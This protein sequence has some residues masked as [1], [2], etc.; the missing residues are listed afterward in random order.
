MDIYKKNREIL[1]RRFPRFE[2]LL[3]AADTSMYCVESSR[4]GQ[5]VPL[6]TGAGGKKIAV[7]SKYEPVKEAER[8]LSGVLDASY[9]LYIVAGFGFAYHLEILLDAMKKDSV[10]LVLDHDIAA[11][12]LALQHRDLSALLADERF[13][14]LLDPDDDEIAEIL[15]GRSSKNVSIIA[16]RGSHQCAADY[17][18]NLIRKAKAY[19]STKE[20]NIATLAKFEKLWTLNCVKNMR[21]FALMPGA[22]VFYG[23]FSDCDAIVVCAGPSL[24]NDLEWLKS[25]SDKAV[26][27]G[28]DTSYTVLANAGIQPH[29]CLCVDPQLINARYFEGMRETTTVIVA[30]PT[31]HSAVFRFYRGRGVISSMPFDMMKWTEQITGE[32]GEMTHGGSVSTNACDFAKRLGVRRIFLLGQDLS[33]TKDRAHVKGSY[34]DELLHNSTNRFVT[35][36]VQNRRQVRALPPLRMPS[37]S[38]AEV[39]TNQKMMIFYQWF[40]RHSSPALFNA[41]GDGLLFKNIPHVVRDGIV[42]A[43]PQDGAIARRIDELFSAYNASDGVIEEIRDRA[44]RLYNESSIL[45][46]KLDRALVLT[47]ELGGERSEKKRAQIIEKL[48]S[49]D[50]YIESASSAKGMVG[51]A[52]QRVIHTI[53]EGYDEGGSSVLARSEYLYS[54][55]RD[56]ALFVSRSLKKLMILLD[57]SSQ[58]D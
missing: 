41:S 1:A 38:G 29:F 26:I 37:I 19:L 34:L 11:F 52:V 31:V 20:V 57:S 8:F 43:E 21:H 42:F 45:A 56:G 16:H 15:K 22:N 23:R 53:T 25:V 46:E 12:K 13:L 14:Y 50:R 35:R 2:T 10:L 28:V 32:K 47:D 55:L 33:F 51:L 58:Q 24:E 7:H 44:E 6:Y 4:T 5:P 17:Y 27:V 54:G 36:L 9:N 18:Q 48:E 3:D 30:D 40:E 39:V 49:V